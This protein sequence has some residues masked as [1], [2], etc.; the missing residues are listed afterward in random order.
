MAERIRLTEMKA[1]NV[2]DKKSEPICTLVFRLKTLR[3][4][5]PCAVPLQSLAQSEM[6]YDLQG[7]TAS[8]G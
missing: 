6:G 3:P 7:P 1:Y 8:L 2:K 5:R 4:A